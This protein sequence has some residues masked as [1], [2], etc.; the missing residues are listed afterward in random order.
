[1]KTKLQVLA[2]AVA[3]CAAG[4]GIASA[5]AGWKVVGGQVRAGEVA[6]Y[7][8]NVAAGEEASV[9]VAGARG[10]R[11]EVSVEDESGQRIGRQSGTAVEIR[12]TPRESGKVV[13]RV[14]NRGE[15]TSAY[16]LIAR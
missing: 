14:A 16:E 13:V 11:L 12:W 5:S 2:I 3:L 10:S 1:M 4:L 15:R 7:L 8:V 6:R 9:R